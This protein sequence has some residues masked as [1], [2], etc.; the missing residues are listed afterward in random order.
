[1]IAR[2]T[3][4]SM[5][6]SRVKQAW[7]QFHNSLIK[8]RTRVVGLF[9][10]E[11]SLLRLVTSVLVEISDAQES[12]NRSIFLIDKFARRPIPGRANAFKI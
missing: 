2:V 7:W 12:R 8:R 6:A 1:M 9:P 3:S 11:E 5:A 4:C 10:I